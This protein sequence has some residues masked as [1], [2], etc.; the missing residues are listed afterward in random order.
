[1]ETKGEGVVA[2]MQWGFSKQGV[3]EKG[4]KGTMVQNNQKYKR[5]FW[6]TCSSDRSFARTVHLFACSALLPSPACSAA[7][8]R[9]LTHSRAHEK[10]SA[11]CSEP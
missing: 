6:A 8:I 11:G 9:S 10:V 1:M 3:T 2:K 7:L 4:G 5:K